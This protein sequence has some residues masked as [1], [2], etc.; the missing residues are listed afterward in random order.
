ME[1]KEYYKRNTID[2]LDVFNSQNEH[3]DSLQTVIKWQGKNLDTLYDGFKEYEKYGEDALEYSQ[4]LN[5][6]LIRMRRTY[7]IGIPLAILGGYL[8]ND[9]LNN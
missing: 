3:I 4:K 6:K 8:L 5:R 1:F 7:R 9:A 2:L